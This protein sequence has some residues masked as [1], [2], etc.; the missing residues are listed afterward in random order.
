DRLRVGVEQQLARV[1]AMPLVRSVRAVD[2]IAVQETGPR[3]RQV[4]MP[5]L[6]GV[7]A[8]LDRRRR[9]APVALEK[10][11]LHALRVLGEQREVDA[12]AVPGSAERIGA[13]RPDG[14]ALRRHATLRAATAAS[15]R[16]SARDGWRV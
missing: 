2:A 1:E 14:G 7:L 11:E 12:L 9:G 3:E 10:H 6:I 13:A 8:K 4:A 15:A 5:H 16:A